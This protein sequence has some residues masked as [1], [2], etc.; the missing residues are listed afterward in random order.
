MLAAPSPSTQRLRRAVDVQFPHHRRLADLRQ[1]N[2]GQV[3]RF[4]GQRKPQESRQVA[5]GRQV[6]HKML[7]GDVRFVDHILK[8][9]MFE[10]RRLLPAQLAA[11][12]TLT[13]QASLLHPLLDDL[14]QIALGRSGDDVL[15]GDVA[16]QPV[17]A[18]IRLDGRFA[19]DQ[20]LNERFFLVGLI[21]P[22]L[23]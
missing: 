4:V 16:H 18:A 14:P 19:A 22:L 3:S 15:R 10:V 20:Q 7:R 9:H 6:L 13:M 12:D 17:D 11:A 21:F 23:P 5:F 1:G 2:L 8:L